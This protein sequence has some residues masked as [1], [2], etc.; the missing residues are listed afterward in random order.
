MAISGCVSW[1]ETQRVL[2][3]LR[4][5]RGGAA[6][7]GDGCCPLEFGRDARIRRPS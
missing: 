1:G 2:G 3:K 5:Q 4:G 7:G 6:L